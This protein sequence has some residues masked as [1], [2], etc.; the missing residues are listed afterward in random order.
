MKKEEDT[1]GNNLKLMGWKEDLKHVI[2]IEV[3]F[4]AKNIKL[5]NKI[6]KFEINRRSC[7]NRKKSLRIIYGNWQKKN[8]VLGPTKKFP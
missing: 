3:L 6:V 4:L 2:D 8:S 5:R 7:I 1:R